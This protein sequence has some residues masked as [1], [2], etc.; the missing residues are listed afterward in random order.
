V[1]EIDRVRLWLKFLQSMADK[2]ATQVNCID[3]EMGVG[4]NLIVAQRRANA[5][6]VSRQAD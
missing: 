2:E 5:I 6:S 1:T 3:R 4:G